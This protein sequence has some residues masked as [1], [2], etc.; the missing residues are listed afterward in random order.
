MPHAIFARAAIVTFN[1]SVL[2][3]N[4]T[5]GATGTIEHGL[6]HESATYDATHRDRLASE[7]PQVAGPLREDRLTREAM[8]TRRCICSLLVLC[9]SAGAS[10]AEQKPVAWDAVVRG[11]PSRT[12]KQL[13]AHEVQLV[14]RVNAYFNQL[15]MLEGSFLQTASDGKQQ[16]GMLHIKRPG[17][18]RFEFAPPNRVVVISD[19]TQMAIQDYNLKTDDR[20]E[21]RRTPFHALLGVN[22]DLMRDTHLLDI[23]E[24][25]D[26]LLI[27]FSDDR[28]EVGSVTLLLATRPMQLKGWSVRDNQNLVTKIDVVEIKT[29]DRIDERL[30]DLAAR[31]ERRQW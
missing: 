10:A 7:R 21:L 4:D 31:I 14:Q 19:G 5:A 18:F 26:T 23:R 15:G 11:A 9:A 1:S 17:R 22:V 28:A 6:C 30:F 12:G 3:E 24:A 2:H 29:V 25:A 20:K 13:S 8:V 27:E 16:R